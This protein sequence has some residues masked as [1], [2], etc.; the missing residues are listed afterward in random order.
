MYSLLHLLIFDLYLCLLTLCIQHVA[1]STSFVTV[2]L[3]LLVC[4]CEG[5][6]TQRTS[7]LLFTIT[8]RW[9]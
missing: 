8:C 2:L 5:V 3:G 6:F 9:F 4:C 7:F 1:V